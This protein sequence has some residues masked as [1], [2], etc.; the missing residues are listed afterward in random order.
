MRLN[1]AA[2]EKRVAKWTSCRR[3]VSVNG[4]VIEGKLNAQAVEVQRDPS[5]Y[6]FTWLFWRLSLCLSTWGSF[7]LC[8]VCF[9]TSQFTLEIHRINNHEMETSWANVS[10]RSL[11]SAGRHWESLTQFRELACGK[12]TWCLQ[13]HLKMIHGVLLKGGAPTWGVFTIHQHSPAVIKQA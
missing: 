5:F 1:G 7:M 13:I 11:K 2:R 6:T 12:Y 4:L 3:T 10:S 8:R 9:L